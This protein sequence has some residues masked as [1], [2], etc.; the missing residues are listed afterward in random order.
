[1]TDDLGKGLGR[2]REKERGPLARDPRILRAF[3][4]VGG[5]KGAVARRVHTRGLHATP[6]NGDLRSD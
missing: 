2:E 6:G 1:M 4:S 5:E 3:L